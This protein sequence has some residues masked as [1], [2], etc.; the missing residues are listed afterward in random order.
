[1]KYV[2]TV[3]LVLLIF[4]AVASGIS[5]IALTQQDV[6]FFGKYGFSQPAVVAFGVVQLI[7]GVL[8]M[9]KRTRFIGTTIVAITFLFSL[10]LLLMDGNMPMSA[11]TI[12]ATLFLA[13]IMKHS[14]KAAE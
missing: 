9:V 1:M 4:L 11:A 8:M 3:L 5:K 2:F 13:A 12:I 10:V 14:W 7:G 6:S